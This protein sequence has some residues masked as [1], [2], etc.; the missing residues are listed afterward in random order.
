MKVDVKKMY[1]FF[2]TI[3][4]LIILFDYYSGDNSLD[5]DGLKIIVYLFIFVNFILVLV[6]FLNKKSLNFSKILFIAT[7]AFIIY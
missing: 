3:S 2:L 5:N 1:Q 4:A 7:F 6:S